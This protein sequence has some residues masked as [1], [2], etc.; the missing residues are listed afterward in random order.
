MIAGAKPPPSRSTAVRASEDGYTLDVPVEIPE[1]ATETEDGRVLAVDLGVKKQATCVPIQPTN[2]ADDGEHE[3]VSPPAFIDHSSKDKLFRVKAD[4]GGINDRLAG[5]RRQGK[6][7][8]E[9][10]GHLLSES[11][12]TRRKERRLRRQIQHDVAN[13]LVWVAIL[14]RCEEIVFE[15]LGQLEN[16]ARDGKTAW[17]ISSWARGELL[18]FVEYKAG[19]FDIDFETVNP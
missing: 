19:L 8:T 14:Q 2:D 3:Q 18:D 16:D 1:Q 15:S 9:R 10:F 7:H 17:S 6:D 4:A 13:E 11:R 12:R 5:L